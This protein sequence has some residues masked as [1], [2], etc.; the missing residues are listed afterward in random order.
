MG[1]LTSL[2]AIDG[3][4]FAELRTRRLLPRLVKVL[5][6]TAKPDAVGFS[7]EHTFLSTG[8]DKAW[9]ALDTLFVCTDPI[10]DRHFARHHRYYC[11][12]IGRTGGGYWEP[13]GVLFTLG[14]FTRLCQCVATVLGAIPTLGI[15][16]LC[17]ADDEGLALEIVAPESLKAAFELLRTFFGERLARTGPWPTPDGDV[18]DA[19]NI[20]YY[21]GHYR[22][23]ITFMT[24]AAWPS[25][26][27]K[28]AAATAIVRITK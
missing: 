6:G 28:Q 16:E 27:S 1:C 23:L 22:T 19:R 3:G 4:R 10:A 25:K 13:A 21:L 7:A 8:L 14:S 17:V 9:E 12:T 15:R 20:A 18:I 11:R 24:E 26:P 2:H 5:S